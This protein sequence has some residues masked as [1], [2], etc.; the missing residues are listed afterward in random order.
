MRWQYLGNFDP[1]NSTENHV[2]LA[3]RR[4]G[5]EVVQRQEND[6][7]AWRAAAEEMADFDVTLW[8]RTGWE[9]ALPRNLQR[10]VLQAGQAKGVPVVGFHLDRWWGLQREPQVARELFFRSDL[11]ITA[12]GGH[13]DRWAEAGVNHLWLP[14]GVSGAQAEELGSYSE[15]FDTEIGFVGSW[16]G[17]HDEWAY[18][19]R[20]VRWLMDTYADRF[21]VWEGGVRGRALADLYASVD[22]LVGDSCLAG[23]ATHYWSDR[24]PETLGRGGF[25]IHP[26][27]EGLREHFPLD[28]LATYELGNFGDLADVIAYWLDP[29]SGMERRQVAQRGREH[30][31]AHHT[32]ERRVAQI[33]E[34]L[35]LRGMLPTGEEDRARG[36]RP[37]RVSMD[38]VPIEEEGSVVDVVWLHGS[39]WWDQ[40]LV[41]RLLV[42]SEWA[43]P[44]GYRFR[45]ATTLDL[46]G[47]QGAVLVVPGRFMQVAEVQALLPALAWVLL[48]VTS[49]EES[50]F[51]WWELEHPN[52]RLWVQT[53]DRDGSFQPLGEGFAHDFPEL[54]GRAVPEKTTAWSFAGQVTHERRQEAVAAMRTMGDG[55]L[56]GTERFLDE[57]KGLGREEYAQLLA[58]SKLVP[59]PSGP[60]TPDTFRCW[61]ALEAGALPI[62]DNR[63]PRD[64]RPGYWP[65]LIGDAPVPRI[66]H[67]SDL[68]ELAQR[69][70]GGWPANANRAQAWWLSWKRR[71]AWRLQD[72]LAELIGSPGSIADLRSLVTVVVPTSPIPSHPD[73][74]VIEQTIASVRH[75]LPESEVIVVSDGVRAEQA[76]MAEAYEEYRRRLLWACA[77]SWP[78]VLPVLLDHHA[79]QA[80]ATKRALELVRTPL[81]LYVEHDTPLTTHEPLPWEGLCRAVLTGVANS[82]R[83]HHEAGVLEPHE[84][85]MLDRQPIYPE[86]VPMLRTIQWS[87]RPHLASTEFYRSLL[88]RHF[89]ES[90][91]TMI[92]D[93]MHSVAQ[94]QPWE[95]TKLW[96][97]APP[98][99]MKR[100]LHLDGRQGEPKFDMVYR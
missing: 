45:Q 89:P 76:H 20:L 1:E 14:P 4:A 24:I 74:G 44:G 94:Q 83:F 56:V 71:L 39:G 78:N 34:A 79:H 17:Y 43:L 8:T 42:G 13:D 29:Q 85:L 16:Q 19:G 7:G 32:Y 92:E 40:G 6:L 99:D 47:G 38:L 12:D 63:T 66:D 64:D 72:D 52:M 31:L 95:A 61:E 49:D 68:P 91:R 67:W 69:L 80:N 75:H 96:L 36:E 87:Q 28:T 65:R 82:V 25:L 50:T 62:L 98:G 33:V 15:E 84:Y 30:V 100:S 60:E 54:L 35:E 11:V 86:G 93:K 51:S 27:V 48:I 46:V 9:P 23:G 53:A 41:M 18:R 2:A 22:V 55:M 5:H 58:A 97:Y 21:R 26:L 73:L 70:L 77:R 10:L 90:A 88:G 3:L 59:C 37:L 81:V 57:E